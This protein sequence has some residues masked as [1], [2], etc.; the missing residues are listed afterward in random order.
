[1]AEPELWPPCEAVDHMGVACSRLAVTTIA[2][3]G[4]C[5]QHLGW[6][7]SGLVYL[8]GDRQ[9]RRVETDAF[10]LVNERSRW[11]SFVREWR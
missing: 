10:V 6:A 5:Q 9:L 3:V 1:M 8:S 11:A 4:L 7:K 2:D